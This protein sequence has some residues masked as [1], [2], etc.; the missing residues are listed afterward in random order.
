LIARTGLL[1]LSNIEEIEWAEP[2]KV[3][4]D[5]RVMLPAVATDGTNVVATY[6][7]GALK[8]GLYTS[9]GKMVEEN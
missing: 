5:T 4:H 2:N 3:I 9:V 6:S 7:T 1:S 8:L